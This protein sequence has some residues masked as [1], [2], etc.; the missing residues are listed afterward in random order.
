M[1]FARR[2]SSLSWYRAHNITIVG[3]YLDH[4]DLA[5]GEN[6]V[7]RFFIN[8]VLLRLLYAHALVAAPGWRW[9]GWRRSPPGSA[10]R[11]AP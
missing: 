3:A 9:G 1:A 2:P 7:E 8:L 6:R 5:E 11:G 4:R 10:T